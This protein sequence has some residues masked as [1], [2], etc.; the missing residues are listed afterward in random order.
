M[1]DP[2]RSSEVF[3][4]ERNKHFERSLNIKYNTKNEIDRIIDVKNNILPKSSFEPLDTN[5]LYFH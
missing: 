1:Q 2:N 5:S 4:R 3:M